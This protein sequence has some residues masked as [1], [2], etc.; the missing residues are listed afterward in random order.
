MRLC[1]GEYVFDGETRELL[2]AGSR[3]HVPAKTFR[4]IEV[5]LERRPV[6][7]SKEKLMEALWPG[8][9]VADG[10]LARLVAELRELVGDD[11]HEPRFIRTIHGFG[12]AFS[13]G[14]AEEAS[15]RRS[16]SDVVYKL[17]M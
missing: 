8:I 17:L 10:N 11:A 16:G 2:R 15:A 9:F 6:A 4:L 1:F 5:L 3:V 13:G 7:V 14:V 12:Y